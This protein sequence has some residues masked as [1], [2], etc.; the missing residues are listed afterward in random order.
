MESTA[1]NRSLR[2]ELDRLIDNYADSPEHLAEQVGLITSL[3]A[4]YGAS[5]SL[6]TEKKP[7]ELEFNCYQY[8]FG[9]ADVEVVTEIMRRYGYIFPNREFVQHLIATRLR[10]IA[11]KDAKDGDHVLYAGSQIEHAGRIAQGSVESKWGKGHLWRHGLFE[12]PLR[13]G[14][15]VRVFQHI[16]QE[17]SIEAFLDYTRIKAAV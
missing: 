5:I 3:A 6:V 17:D 10:E 15:T 14:D 1:N 8:S 7:G 4:K 11:A 13:Y 12:I 16:S 9:L 2:E